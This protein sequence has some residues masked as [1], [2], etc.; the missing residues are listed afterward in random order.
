VKRTPE[1]ARTY[2]TM[3][4]SVSGRMPRRYFIDAK[5]SGSDEV[6]HSARGGVR[7][8]EPTQLVRRVRDALL[9][10]ATAFAVLD[11]DRACS[12]V[13]V[14]HLECEQL[15]LAETGEEG[16]PEDREGAGAVERR[17]PRVVVTDREWADD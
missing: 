12:E 3:R 7:R 4:L 14:L 10:A 16:Y 17:L 11:A 2:W 13:D 15:A 9:P 8:E 1:A 6:R 5:Y